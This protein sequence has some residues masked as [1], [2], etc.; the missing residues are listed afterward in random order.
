MKSFRSTGNPAS[1]A[2][3]RSSS[4]P[5]KPL[6]SVRTE[7]AAAPPR[8][9]S[10]ASAAGSRFGARDPL[11]GEARF[12]SAIADMLGPA[13]AAA[14]PLGASVK[15]ARRTKDLRSVDARKL[16]AR[17]RAEVTSSSRKDTRATL[18]ASLL[19]ESK[20]EGTDPIGRSFHGSVANVIASEQ[21]FR[22]AR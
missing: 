9:N 12:I 7:I 18:T 20:K 13:S 4:D 1:L 8:A 11:E 16:S 21:S 19:Q 10:F 15:V 3:A 14:N 2:A 6:G 17:A 22:S 5:S